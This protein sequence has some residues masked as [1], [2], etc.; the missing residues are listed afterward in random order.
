MTQALMNCSYAPVFSLMRLL[1]EDLF[2]K[3]M[4]T[5][6]LDLKCFSKRSRGPNHLPK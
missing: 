3:E 2:K 1:P 5:G 6:L 4:F